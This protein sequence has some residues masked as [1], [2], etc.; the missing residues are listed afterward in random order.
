MTSE[1]ALSKL[2]S[3]ASASGDKKQIDKLGKII[4]RDLELLEYYKWVESTEDNNYIKN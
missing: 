3:L 2:L 1:E 4:K